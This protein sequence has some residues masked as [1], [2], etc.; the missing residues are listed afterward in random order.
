MNNENKL[1]TDAEKL[2][3]WLDFSVPRGEYN[4]MKRRLVEECLISAS[5]LKNWMY[6]QCRIPDSG[7]RDINRVTLDYS[8]VEIFTI[9]KPGGTSGG[10][11]GDPAGKAVN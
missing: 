10:V 2:R 6:G 8:G 3:H 7:K 4:N 1:L 5:T 11:C 9:A